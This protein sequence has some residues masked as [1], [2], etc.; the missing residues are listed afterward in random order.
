MKQNR[1]AAILLAM[2]FAFLLP[3]TMLAQKEEKADKDKAKE[4]NKVEQVII[5]KK[6]DSK[7]KVVIEIIDD[8]VTI[9]GKEVEEYKDK[10]G[11]VT[12]IRTRPGRGVQM[13][14]DRVFDPGLRSR[15][16][17]NAEVF[18]FFNENSNKAMLGVTTE[19]TEEGV[20]VKSVTKESAAEKIGL[21]EG[22]I[23]TKIDGKEINSSDDLSEIIQEHKPGDK[24][25]VTYKRDKKTQTETAELTKWKGIN[26]WSGN[27]NFDNNFNMGDLYLDKVMPRIQSIPRMSEPFG[28]YF[29]I[30]GNRPKLGITVQDTDDGKGVKVLEVDE[31]SNAAKAGVKEGDIITE[32]DGKAINGTD[33]M[34]KMVRENKDKVSV[35]LKLNRDGKTQNIEVKMPRLLKK[36]DL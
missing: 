14:N 30:A 1:K 6:G 33:D 26:S 24:V 25:K 11:N 36:A 29:G 35:M 34:V 32:A 28:Q 20:E 21:K 19:K 10:D 2:G 18:E 7:D 17:N 4:K 15:G 12:I 9:N 27:F 8:K 31:E 5:T 23:I 3:A 13:W 16:G 22:D